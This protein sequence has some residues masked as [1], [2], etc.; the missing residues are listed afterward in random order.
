MQAL[1]VQS[2]A[3][4]IKSWVYFAC[5]ANG[6]SSLS[7]KISYR[8]RKQFTRILGQAFAQKKLIEFSTPLWARADEE[9][10]RQVVIHEAC[11]IIAY[12]KY[13]YGIK[14]HG[15]E[16]KKCMVEAGVPPLRCHDVNRYGLKK[17]YVKYAVQ[18]ARTSVWVGHVRAA[19]VRANKLF[20]KR[21]KKKLKLTGQTYRPD[22]VDKRTA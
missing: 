3:D 11:H 5:Q 4:K 18:C 7:A 9:Q 10:R 15:R 1:V 13:G 6:V 20:C 16:W 17:Q 19:K 12:H 2:E 22:E 14:A 21:C 8:F